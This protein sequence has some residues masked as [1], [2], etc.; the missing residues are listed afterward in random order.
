M[1]QAEHAEAGVSGRSELLEEGARGF[2]VFSRGRGERAGSCGPERGGLCPIR[3]VLGR[4][5]PPWGELSELPDQLVRADPNVEMG[6]WGLQSDWILCREVNSVW[7]SSCGLKLPDLVFPSWPSEV[8]QLCAHAQETPF[9]LGWGG[10][11]EPRSCFSSLP[12]L[13]VGCGVPLRAL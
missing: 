12:E 11:C 13:A 2:Q 9:A 3:M 4:E 7:S 8:W 1:R 10:V 6:C 5:L